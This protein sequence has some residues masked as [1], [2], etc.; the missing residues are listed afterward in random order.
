[1]PYECSWNWLA[2]LEIS[3]IG[4]ALAASVQWLTCQSVGIPSSGLDAVGLLLR[5]RRLTC[6][7]SPTWTGLDTVW[8]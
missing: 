5:E 6:P 4:R 2:E 7:T 1:V 8:C 3:A